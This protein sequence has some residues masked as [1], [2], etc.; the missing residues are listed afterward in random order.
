[1]WGLVELVCYQG[2]LMI[3]FVTADDLNSEFRS[4]LTLMVMNPPQSSREFFGIESL[5]RVVLWKEPQRAN[6]VDPP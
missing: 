6:P 1:M 3:I 4:W 5:E 2:D